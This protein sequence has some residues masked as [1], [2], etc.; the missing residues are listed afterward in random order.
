MENDVVSITRN[1]PLNATGKKIPVLILNVNI[2][3]TYS[4]NTSPNAGNRQQAVQFYFR[5]SAHG[6]SCILPVVLCGLE[7]T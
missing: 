3:L 7:Q 6:E 4:L 2:I 5:A 1:G